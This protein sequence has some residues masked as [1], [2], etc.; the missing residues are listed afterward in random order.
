MIKKAVFIAAV[1]AV[2][3]LSNTTNGDIS[4]VMN[5]SFE[6]DG[7]IDPVTTADVPQYWCDINMP[8]SNFSGKVDMVWSTHGDYSLTLSS[9]ASS[10]FVKGDMM[11]VSQQVYFADANK[12]IFDIGLSGTYSLFP[13]DSENFS[14]VVQIDYVDVW[15][16]NDNLPNGNGEYTVEVNDI[17]ISDENLHTLSLVM[18]ANRN[19]THSFK[20]LVRWDFVKFDMYCGGLGYLWEDLNQDCYV[21][22]LDFEMLTGQWLAEDPDMEYDLYEDGIIDFRDFASFADYWMCNTDWANW[23]DDNCFEMELPAGDLNNDGIVNLYDF[24]ILSRDWREEGN[25]NKSDI[26]HSGT[27]DYEDLS[28]PA[29]QWLQISWLSRL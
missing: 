14:A 9:K 28:R 20:Y 2:V 12:I 17:N 27:V 16:S 5:G 21:N 26:D 15:D 29:D 13:W 4:L 1:M 18:R 25:C 23:Q 7:E 8:T 6:N 24:A 3:L 10:T 22:M 19:D 11:G